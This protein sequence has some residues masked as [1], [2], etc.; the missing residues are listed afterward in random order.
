VGYRHV[1]ASCAH[2][3]VVGLL[4]GCL[5][6]N[7]RKKPSAKP[8]AR[9][10]ATSAPASAASTSRLPDE[11]GLYYAFRVAEDLSSI[12]A[13][14][15][16]VGPRPERLVPQIREASG[17]LRSATASGGPLPTENGKI[18]LSS[19]NHGCV[20]YV[21]DTTAALDADDVHD[22]ASLIGNDALLSPDWWLWAPDGGAEGPVF[23]RFT[24][25]GPH[26]EELPWPRRSRGSFDRYVPPSAFIWKAQASFATRP[27]RVVSV[28]EAGLDVTVIGPGFGDREDA[29]VA[30]LS[31]SANAVAGLL[32]AFP[33]ERAQVLLVSEPGRS[34][35]FGYAL[36]GGGPSA[37]VLLPLRPTDQQ[38]ADDWTAVHELLHFSHPPMATSEAWFYEGL[39]TYFTALAR[40]RSGMTSKRY[41]WWELLDGFKRGSKVGT[42]QTLREECKTMHENR[43]YWRVYWSGAMMLLKMDV[44]L[45]RRGQT[46]EALIGKLVSRRLDES[47]HFTAEELVGKL[48]ALCGCT[49]PSSITAAHL[50]EKAFPDPAPVTKAL[51]V[52]LAEGKSVSY[53]A[54]APD[55][56]IR[57]AIMGGD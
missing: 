34:R 11:P 3:I 50:D 36:R 37:T 28:D 14:V 38:L 31:S 43:T 23:A 39:A 22:G 4:L 10:T 8:S 27:A 44:E 54:A 29:V 52:S 35:S 42:G 30:W 12:T 25:P 45:R 7:Q 20:T 16:F 2:A 9:P 55:A 19:S 33:L 51:G 57:K 53:D 26:R 1:V 13:D 48:D 21:I 32:G 15:C 47:H 46:L 5:S 18:T 56:A 49:I 24:T 40:A 17:L 41:G 6:C